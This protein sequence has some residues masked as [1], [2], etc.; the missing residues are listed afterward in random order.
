MVILALLASFYSMPVLTLAQT[1]ENDTALDGKWVLESASIQKI[2]DRA[3][4]AD[5]D[6]LKVDVDTKKE[7]LLFALYDTLIFKADTLT[8]YFGD[9]ENA[10]SQDKYSWTDN[11]I[12]INFMPAPHVMLYALKDEKLYFTQKTSL[13]C[14]DCE[15]VI[16]TIYKKGRHENDD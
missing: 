8:I 3:G 11:T 1:G 15:Y 9:F 2:T 7:D 12:E 5:R 13:G 6:T 4:R 16:Q 10:V 14:K